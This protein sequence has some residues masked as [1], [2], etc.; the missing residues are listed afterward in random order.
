MKPDWLAGALAL[1]APY[2]TC[3]WPWFHPLETLTLPQ[4]EQIAD[5]LNT[6]GRQ[7]K[8]AGLIFAVHNHDRDFAPLD[9]KPIFDR[10]LDLTD[11][12]LVTVEL[13]IYWAVKAGVDPVEYFARYPGRFHLFHVKDMDDTPE[14]KQ[15]AIGAGTIDFARIFAESELAGVKHYIVELEGPSNNTPAAQQSAEY[16]KTL[17]F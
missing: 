6:C 7:C 5:Q 9:G 16:L 14:K 11:P 2:A 13:D 15:A 12:D 1:K 8:E 10:L 17:R 3:F 4:L